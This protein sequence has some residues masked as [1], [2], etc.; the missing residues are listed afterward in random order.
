MKAIFLL[1][2]ALTCALI[3]GCSG[4]SSPDPNAT[5]TPTI[6]RAS[7]LHTWT[8]RSLSKDGTTVNCP[9]ELVFVG[10]SDS[11]EAGTV[12]YNADGT[13]TG[14]GFSSTWTLT[15]NQLRQSTD[16]P[17]EFITDTVVGLTSS[18]LLI[19]NSA[20]VTARFTR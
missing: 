9:G 18:E 16:T 8:V 1:T 12:T 11:C 2:L 4:G 14:G 3:F 10:G 13:A 17:G 20:G 7:L 15:G 5:P 6:D 19:L